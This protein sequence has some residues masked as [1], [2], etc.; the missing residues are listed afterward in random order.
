MFTLKCF[1]LDLCKL[2]HLYVTHTREGHL[3]FKL[4]Q[5][6]TKSP[7]APRAP[8]HSAEIVEQMF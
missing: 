7:S 1:Y 5:L 6:P 4:L 2:Q 8:T 3:K